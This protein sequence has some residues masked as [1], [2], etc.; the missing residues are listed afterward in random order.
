MKQF[1]FRNKMAK[2]STIL[3]ALLFGVVGLVKSQPQSFS[4][5]IKDIEKID[6]I[7]KGP[8]FGN[9]DQSSSTKPIIE[10]D[11]KMTPA[12]REI[13]KKIVEEDFMEFSSKG[14]SF[15]QNNKKEIE[16]KIKNDLETSLQTQQKSNHQGQEKS[17]FFGCN[18]NYHIIWICCPWRL[19]IIF[20][21]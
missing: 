15:V 18:F 4:R 8:P 13:A 2:Q 1:H 17:L 14:N 5:G 20:Y 21:C 16:Q 6:E 11:E 12:Q 19:I 3:L 10:F 9:S 7:V